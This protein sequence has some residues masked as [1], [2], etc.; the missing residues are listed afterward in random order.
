MKILIT[1]LRRKVVQSLTLTA[2]LATTT[3]YSQ[4]PVPSSVGAAQ[5]EAEA[6]KLSA[7]DLEDLVGPIALYPDALVALILPAAT[8]PSDITLAARYLKQYGDDADVA[9]QP[10]DA[11][12]RSLANYPDVLKW[13]DE[14]LE[15]T[16]ALGEAFV[17]QPTDVMNAVQEL[18]LA[19]KENGNLR[20]TPQQTVVVEKAAQQ[21]VVR[22]VVRIVPTDPEVIYVPVYDPEVVY[23]QTYRPNY[24]PF[25][26]FGIGLAVGSWLN[27]DCDWRDRGIYYGDGCG[28]NN[29][30]RWYDRGR[31]DRDNNVN[32][33]TTVN[34]TNIT[35]INSVVNNN[36]G[37][38]WQPNA[39]S[40]RFYDQR[41]SQNIGNA[42]VAR[43]NA[44]IRSADARHP[45]NNAERAALAANRPARV[46][47]PDRP[48]AITKNIAARRASNARVAANR[49]SPDQAN[50]NGNKPN[51]A[52]NKLANRPK[53]ASSAPKVAG[54]PD[55]QNAKNAGAKAPNARKTA[56]NPMRKP[57]VAPSVQNSGYVASAA[58]ARKSNNAQNRKKTDAPRQNAGMNRQS[59]TPKV[60]QQKVQKPQAQASKPKQ[61]QVKKSQQPSPRKKQVKQQQPRPQQ[62][63]QQ[64]RPKQQTQQKPQQMRQ[65]SAPKKQPAQKQGDGSGDKRQSSGDEKKKKKN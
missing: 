29:R 23:V 5:I 34:N 7:E 27:Y 56:D 35:N 12:V 57:G 30:G 54:Q 24:N 62:A 48:K 19:A 46:A 20:N 4:T 39:A 52:P 32:V 8:V 58:T 50:K 11:S 17:V 6:E 1:R 65:Q 55:K 26:T 36:R 42:R 64:A 63:Q 33:I 31:Y 28:W 41:R 18:R 43:A 14:N 22:E 45:K 38:R 60:S 25:V 51:T 37:N 59:S 2:L 15:W 21:K 47:K 44:A 40:R 9:D 53:P 3:L 16:T 13:M 49:L 10:W 61:Q